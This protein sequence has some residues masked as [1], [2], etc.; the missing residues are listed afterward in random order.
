[1][2]YLS[3]AVRNSREKAGM[4][5]RQL[6]AMAGLS[7]SYV[8]RLERDELEPTLVV[9][10]AIACALNWSPSDVNL[11]MRLHLVESR[12]SVEDPV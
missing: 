1:M 11:T 3:D 7:P 9:F 6:S 5:C 8:A 2:S 4:S 10:T 12:R